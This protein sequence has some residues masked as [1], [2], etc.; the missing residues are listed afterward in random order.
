MLLPVLT[1]LCGIPSRRINPLR[2]CVVSLG[3][4]H[5]G[6]VSNVI[7]GE[8]YLEGTIRATDSAVREQLWHEVE[9]AI[10]IC[11]AMGGKYEFQLVKG[12]PPMYNH[13]QVNDWMRQ[14]AG[15]LLGEAGVKEME[16]GMGAEDFSYMTQAAKGAM[17]MLGAAT[18][19]GVA[20]NH[21]TDTFDIDEAAL[22]IGA[23]V[24]AETARRYVTGQYGSSS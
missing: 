14:V 15:D 4:V 13:K 16:F 3:K 2:E 10:S 6:E 1:A 24:L 11:E 18:P 17:F 22:A 19:D 7:P 12:F 9:Q 5:A 20:R 21:H 8:A 23:A